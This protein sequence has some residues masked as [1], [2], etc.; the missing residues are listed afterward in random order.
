MPKQMKAAAY[1][2]ASLVDR[3]IEALSNRGFLRRAG[4][5][6]RLVEELYPLSR[7]GL[8]LKHPGLAVEVEAFEDSGGPD[9]LI[10]IQGFQ[11]RTFEVQITYADYGYEEALRSEL[12][13]EKGTCPGAGEIRRDKIAGAV[14]AVMGAVDSREHVQRISTAVA[15]RL[16]AKAQKQCDRSTVL[17][18]AFHEVKLY[19]WGDWKEVLSSVRDELDNSANPFSEVYLFNGARNELRGVA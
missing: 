11:E 7:L 12:L 6:K 3:E 9:G 4:R 18:I 1:E 5:S 2:F 13:V 17:L 19:G 15:E 10:S 16:R 14:V 8:H